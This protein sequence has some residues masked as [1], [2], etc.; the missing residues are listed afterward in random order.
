M[1]LWKSV[2]NSIAAPAGGDSSGSSAGAVARACVGASEAGLDATA[3]TSGAG[4]VLAA[5]GAQP[6]KSNPITKSPLAA[7]VTASP[8]DPNGASLRGRGQGR[9]APRLAPRAGHR[10]SPGCLP[11]TPP[12]KRG[13][14]PSASRPAGN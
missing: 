3:A 4:A 9:S 8:P 6:D 14:P 10:R 7:G 12:E 2:L 1:C 11:G 13:P 5:P